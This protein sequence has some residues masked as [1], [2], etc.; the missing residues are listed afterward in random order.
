MSNAS[1]QCGQV[2]FE[3][4]GPL[5]QVYYCYCRTCRKLGGS[6][7]SLVTRV[8]KSAFRII[9]GEGNLVYY[10]S[11]PGKKR[12][13]CQ[14]CFSP[15]YVETQSQPNF[16]R[17]RLGLLDFEPNVDIVGHIWLSHKPDYLKID[18]TLPQ[19]DEWHRLHKSKNALSMN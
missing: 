15:I 8:D 16:V 11:S 18:D 10:E 1:C 13:H 9:T 12:Y 5:S 3:L 7:F 14:H 19:F 6:A 17:V 2:K 4:K